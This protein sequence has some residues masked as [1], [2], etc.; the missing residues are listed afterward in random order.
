MSRSYPRVPA[1]AG[2]QSRS[3]LR[4]KPWAPV[5]G[6]ALL[7]CAAPAFAQQQEEPGPCGIEVQFSEGRCGRSFGIELPSDSLVVVTAARAEQDAREVGQAVTTLTREQLDRR[8]TQSVADLLATTPG[9]TVTRNGSVGGFTGVRIRGAEAEQTLVVIDG[10]RVNDPSSPGG[11]FDFANLLSTSVERVEVLRGPNSVPWGSQAIGGVVNI[12]TFS[13]STALRTRAEGGSYGTAFGSVGGTVAT[14]PVLAGATVGY[15]TSDGVSAAAAGRERDGYRQIGGAANLSVDVT[16]GFAIDLR[17]YYAHSRTE[18][19]GFPPPR[20]T[21]GD[22]DEY[23]TAQE[24]YA[25]AGARAETGPVRHRLAFTLADINRDN[26]ATSAGGVPTFLGRGRSERYEYQVDARLLDALRLVAGAERENVRFSDGNL[27]PRTGISSGFAQLIAKPIKPL[28]L[29]GGVRH[30]E[31]DQF[32]GRTTL[33]ANAALALGGT[34]LRGSYGEGFKAPTLFQLFSNFGNRQLRSE[35]AE[36]VD[37]G[38]EQTA[39]NGALR[40][41]VTLFTRRTRNQID[42]RACSAAERATPGSICVGR[43]FGTYDNIARTRA[44]GVELGLELRPV[45][46]FV[47]EGAYSHIASENRSPGANLGRDLARR[48]RDTASLS[49]DYRFGFGLQLGGTVLMVGDSF[50]DVANRVRLDGYA[51]ASLRA[52]LPVGERLVLYGRV[53]N[54][55]DV[56]YQTVAG[57]GVLG[58]AAHGGLRLRFE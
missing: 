50:D 35:T 39:L 54:L 55:G 56:R 41:S 49:A 33:G 6:G 9:I 10:V 38:V 21:L 44:R 18:L 30:D 32:G 2:T 22:T 23:S 29:T 25:Y 5:W 17:A 1:Q 13:T 7:A 28:T 47:V 34:V 11:G 37:L 15:L 8:Q 43:P 53:D 57:Y 42:F 48:P 4:L 40:A 31:H 24:L 16:D 45:P 14:G 46:G 51:L 58:R 36:N 19:D 12:S 52:E 20:F 26:F 3:G 27:R